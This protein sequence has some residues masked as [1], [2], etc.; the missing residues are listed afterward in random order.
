MDIERTVGCAELGAEIAVA[1]RAARGHP[2]TPAVVGVDRGGH[3]Q[4]NEN[5]KKNLHRAS[6]AIGS[7]VARRVPAEMEPVLRRTQAGVFKLEW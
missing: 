3:G 1:F 6:A 7:S 5:G 2:A 4:E